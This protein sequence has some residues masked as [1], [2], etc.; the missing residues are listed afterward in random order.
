MNKKNIDY[1]TFKKS[2]QIVHHK[3]LDNPDEEFLKNENNIVIFNP[4]TLISELSCLYN[5]SNNG[6]TFE[7]ISK[8][9]LIDHPRISLHINGKYNSQIVDLYIKLNRYVKYSYTDTNLNNAQQLIMALCTQY[10]FYHASRI[11]T[12]LYSNPDLNE[13]V[14]QHID[15]PKI[16]INFGDKNIDIIYKKIFKLTEMDTQTVKE[17]YHTVT[18]ITINLFEPENTILFVKPAKCIVD[19]AM[20]YWKKKKI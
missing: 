5:Q 7:Q 2:L 9:L 13:Y 14:F 10:T 6:T 4:V 1:E 16:K 18:I 3:S 8:Q 15:R 20:V 12:R 11:L 17:I 19:C